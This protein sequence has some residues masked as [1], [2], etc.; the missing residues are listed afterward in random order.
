MSLI[1]G[2]GSKRRGRESFPSFPTTPAQEQGRLQVS[3]SLQHKAEL[4][5]LHLPASII[6]EHMPLLS[7]A[8]G[9]HAAEAYFTLLH[10]CRMAQSH[11]T[12][13][14]AQSTTG[15]FLHYVDSLRGNGMGFCTESI[16]SKQ[17]LLLSVQM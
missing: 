2:L 11:H 9:S 6:R 5:P 7:G 12:A 13:V 10:A 8:E 15:R 1:D 17:L 3:C 14:C 16:S 4:Q